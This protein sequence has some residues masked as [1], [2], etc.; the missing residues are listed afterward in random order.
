[1][2]IIVP[3][4]ILTPD[5]LLCRQAIAFDRTIEAVGPLDE[6]SARFPDAS[7]EHLGE[8]SLVMPGLINPH[9]HLEFS[10]NK[11]TLTY[12]DFLPWLDS[13]IKNRE[14]LI[15][16][17]AQ[18]CMQQ[19]VDRM[20]ESGIT[21]FGAI[22]SHGMDLETA[23]EA[24]QNV[25]FFNEVIGSQA[26]M[27]DALYGDFLQRLE[28][29]ESIKRD[30]FFPAVAI[31]SPYSVHPI[32]VRRA[33][34]LSRSR[35]LRRSAHFMESPAEREW[36]DTSSGDFKPFFEN[37]LKQTQSVTTADEF[38]ELFEGYPTMMTHVV[39]ARDA[40]LDALAKAG[41]TVVHCPISN[42]LLGN[43]AIDLDALE[44][45]H[46]PW[47]C[48]TDGLSSN[49]D[50]N[51]FEEMKIALFMH[52]ETALLPLATR[53][54]ERATKEA[55]AA[56]DLET[57]AI[58]TGKQADMLVIQLDHAANEQLPLHL[59]LHQFPINRIYINGNI[60]KE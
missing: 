5:Q 32:L 59:L 6:L 40:E 51:L 11:T 29:S 45:H 28:A 8:H 43:G 33:L 10:A 58:E 38:L 12:G 37:F 34:E 22:S 16:G 50:L 55:A 46:V 9:I 41:H 17:C 49:Y 31:H 7:V 39:H 15:N 52:S 21:T 36:L 35:N 48:G 14:T 20:L 23:A 19:A 57:G 56:L 18:E 27:A 26:V 30:G 60:V 4:Y 3:D 54:I 2:T 44:A 25:V 47:V 53:L 42:R 1:V 24:P 13:V